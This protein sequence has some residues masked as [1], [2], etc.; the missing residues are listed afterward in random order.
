MLNLAYQ[1]KKGN[2]TG[3]CTVKTAT[4][5]QLLGLGRSSFIIWLEISFSK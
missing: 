4:A 2:Q 3:G 5:S 1:A